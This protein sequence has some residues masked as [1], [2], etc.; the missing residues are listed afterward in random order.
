MENVKANWKK[1]LLHAWMSLLLLMLFY[2]ISFW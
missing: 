1:S 2:F